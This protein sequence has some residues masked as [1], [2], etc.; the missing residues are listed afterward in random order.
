MS[1]VCLSMAAQAVKIFESEAIFRAPESIVYDSLNK[2]LYVSNYTGPLKDGSFYGNHSLTKIDLEGNI[3]ADKW[4]DGLS[5]PTG[6]CIWED[7]LFIVERFGVVEYNLRE[8]KVTN[9]YYIKTSDFLNDI[10]V[11]KKGSLYVTV[12][13][14][15]KIYRIIEGQV[16]LWIEHDSI[17]NPNGILCHNGIVLVGTTSDGC[18]KTID[19]ISKE[20]KKIAYLGEKTVDGIRPCGEGYL[21]S[22]FEGNLFWVGLDGEVREILNTREEKLFQADFEYIESKGLIFIP[23]LWNNKILIYKYLPE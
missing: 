8:R 6:I 21:V 9:K 19:P 23:A 15:K 5:S 11:D 4:L 7:K 12:S 2:V 22:L 1:L 3:L 16:E 17:D 14:T 13:G 18:L 20:I 10:S